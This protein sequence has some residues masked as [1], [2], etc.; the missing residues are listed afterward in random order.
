LCFVL[1]LRQ[2]SFSIYQ[3]TFVICHLETAAVSS[4]NAEQT[5]WQMKDVK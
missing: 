2:R 4:A 1:D 3:L 5:K